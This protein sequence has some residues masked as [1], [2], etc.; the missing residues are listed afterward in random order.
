MKIL[1]FKTN[2]NC[3]D[4]VAKVTPYLDGEERISM[5]EVDTQTPDKILSVSGE[6]LEPQHVKNL[7]EEAGFK[8]E[9][10]RVQAIGGGDM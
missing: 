3:G 2:I 1:K 7:V 4:C 8:A 5:W 9:V 10:L 6:E